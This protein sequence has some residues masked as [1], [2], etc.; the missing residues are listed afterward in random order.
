[1]SDIYEIGQA[2]GEIRQDIKHIRSEQKAMRSDLKANAEATAW[3]RR[4]IV[5]LALYGGSLIGNIASDQIT[6]KLAS[7]LELY[8]LLR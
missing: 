4:L 8:K 7:I 6:P 3:N 5:L 2:V 1:M